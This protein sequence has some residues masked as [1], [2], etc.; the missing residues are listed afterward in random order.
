MSFFSGAGTAPT[1]SDARVSG[2]YTPTE[3]PWIRVEK[4]R[5]AT[6]LVW[7]RSPPRD[8]MSHLVHE[9]STL[10]TTAFHLYLSRNA[11][12][13]HE[14]EA[15]LTMRQSQAM[16]QSPIDGVRSNGS[17]TGRWRSRSKRVRRFWRRLARVT[18]S[19]A[20]TS[21]RCLHRMHR[22]MGLSHATRR[23]R[24]EPRSR[25]SAEWSSPTRGWG[26]TAASVPQNLSR[27][28]ATEWPACSCWPACS[29]CAP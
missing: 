16:I 2:R 23:H 15:G 18:T 21:S 5:R 25:T 9:S 20:A 17:F 29:E 14:F 11:G 26:S 1:A 28:I 6:P 3:S 27:N 7:N 13:S 12:N 19:Y 24:Q 10:A 8:A 22:R 4:A